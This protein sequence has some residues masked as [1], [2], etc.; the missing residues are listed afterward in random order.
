MTV[1]AKIILP[2][3]VKSNFTYRARPNQEAFVVPGARVLVNFG[4]RKIYTGIIKE[5]W[6]ESR[7]EV[8][9]HLKYIEEV[10]DEAPV[11]SKQQFQLFEWTSYYYLCTEGEVMKAALPAGMKTESS[12]RISMSPDLNWEALD[13]GDKEFVLMEALEHKPTMGFREVAELWQVAN[14]NPRLNVMAERGWIRLYQEVEERYRPKT[15]TFLRLTDLTSHEKGMQDALE[16]VAKY[17]AQESLLMRIISDFFQKAPTPKTETLKELGI[18]GSAVNSLEKKGF[19]VQEEVQVDRLALYGYDQKAVNI[20]LNPEQQRVLGEIRAAHKEKVSRPVLLHGITGSGKTHIYI[21]LIREAL[22]KGQQVLYLLPEITLTKQIVDRIKSEFGSQV[23]VYHSKFNDAERV[24]IW[25]KVNKQEYKV[26]IGVRSA[27]FL[28][29]HHLG[30]I[31]VDEEHDTSFKQFD[32]APRYHARDLAVYLGHKNKIPVVL[33]SATPSFESYQNAL[34]GKYALTELFTRA[35][36][37]ELPDIR[38]VDV[39]AERKTKQMEGVFSK[40]LKEA[41]ELRLQRKEQVILFQNRRGYAPYL[42]CQ[43]CGF[44]PECVNCDINLTYHKQVDH[45]RCHYCGYTEYETQKCPSCHHFALKKMGIG[46]EKIEEDIKAMFPDAEVGRMDYDTTRSKMAFQEIINRFERR[47]LDILV[48]TQMVSKGLDFEHVTLVGVIMA[49]NVLSFPDFRAYEYAFQLLTQVSGRAGRSKKPGEVFVQTYNPQN[50]VV[51][52]IQERKSYGDFF[53]AEVLERQ[54]L[55]YPPS[56]RMLRIETRHREREQV[57]KETLRLEGLLRPKFGQ[58]LLGPDYPLIAR[59]RN[60]YRMQFLLK[61]DKR[62]AAAQL[63]QQL[64]EIIEQYYRK[65]PHKSLRI[66]LDVDPV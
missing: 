47:K 65:A 46:T 66:V 49:D 17:P 37:A 36:D 42:V 31:V 58:A 12:L 25:H 26:L 28:P 29:F 48:G 53:Q 59:M 52:A 38:V 41:I 11:L 8:L 34:Q 15:K 24:E 20:T 60:Q 21:E 56:S 10:V 64:Q 9:K 5:S 13:L 16:T 14:P 2:L 4:K 55:A 44:V 40:Q 27:M 57:E 50:T 23:G 33:G 32:P 18:S 61:I 62:M 22:E 63:R 51:K 35:I 3:A 30:L 6:E 43:N 39:R 1:L 54:Q 19:L 45:L 7:E